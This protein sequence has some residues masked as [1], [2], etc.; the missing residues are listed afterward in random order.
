M[1][2]WTLERS[3][4]AVLLLCLAC[5]LA[6]P[7]AVNNS[8]GPGPGE[9]FEVL[10]GVPVQWYKSPFD[11]RPAH[12][13]LPENSR[14]LDFLNVDC[15]M[16]CRGTGKDI[17]RQSGCP[18][19]P[20]GRPYTYPPLLTCL[21]YWI[22]LLN[23]A[24]AAALWSWAVLGLIFANACFWFYAKGF[25]PGGE[26]G[27]LILKRPFLLAL[28]FT[29]SY[30]SIF[31]FERGNHDVWVLLFV[32]GLAWCLARQRWL[33]AGLTASLAA[34]VKVY[35]FLLLIPL[36][37][38]CAAALLLWLGFRK[39]V[40]LDAGFK[41]LLGAGL[42]LAA[43]IGVFYEP[44]VEYATRMLPMLA[45][46]K[47]TDPANL[48]SHSLPAAFGSAG[49]LGF[50]CLWGVGTFALVLFLVRWI[51]NSEKGGRGNVALAFSYL[52]A[53]MV[54]LA[55]TSYDYNL[56]MLIP[57]LACWMSHPR[58]HQDPLATTGILLL[59]LGA[60]LPRWIQ[61]ACAGSLKF[62]FYLALQCAGWSLIGL[63]LLILAA[64]ETVSALKP[65]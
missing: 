42:G 1:R 49:T 35:P 2:S 28:L 60:A 52:G 18:G 10:F 56:I 5:A 26:N 62:S 63:R 44:T 39:T 31:A 13:A 61:P 20:F 48:F 54:Y 17:Y 30:P 50:A 59:L 9:R 23:T 12:M 45:K 34:L 64:S 14:G 51:L 33:A 32:S 16:R 55:N 37:A 47:L 25:R 4:V 7:L 19:D 38:F 58:T 8:S 27:G 3:V 11:P 46:L 65:D 43:G 53:L 36:I 21:F 15:C 24:Q 29:A 22:F 41:M 40:L 57:L 6:Q